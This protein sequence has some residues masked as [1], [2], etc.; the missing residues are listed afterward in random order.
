MTINVMALVN[1]SIRRTNSFIQ[2]I[3]KIRE[4][5]FPYQYSEEALKLIKVLIEEQV[6]YLKSIGP[7]SN[8]ESSKQLCTTS[9]DALADFLPLLGFIIR[10]TNVRNGFEFYGP[11][12][13]LS[14]QVLGNSDIRLVISS[15]WDYSPLTYQE[16]KGLKDFI[17]IGIPAT[18]S[19]NP[20][21]IP[22]AGHEL[23]HHLWAN[24]T[25]N[26]KLKTSITKEIIK[27]IEAR[28]KEFTNLYPN[29]IDS[30]EDLTTNFFAYEIW[31][32]AVEW[33]IQQSTELFC[34]FIGVNIF[35]EAYLHAFAYLLAPGMS[36]MRPVGYPE[37][38]TRIKDLVLAA[39]EYGI[40]CTDGYIDLYN[41]VFDLDD[42]DS[43]KKFWLEL[44]DQAVK[45]IVPELI[46]DADSI[47]K[48]S[49][50]I[51]FSENKINGILARF[52]MIVPAQNSESLQ[53][54][55]IAGW[56]A[57]H[58]AELWKDVSKITDRDSTLKELI[59]KTIE[60][61]EI[62]HLVKP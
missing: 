62:E 47:V 36:G 23:G 61:F 12:L 6:K 45:S 13:R 31:A 18:E 5:D 14:R 2:E 46:K 21:L 57:F 43:E 29:V 60:V 44:A 19:D 54:I 51:G 20:L 55:L 30:P 3:E 4:T 15:E 49:K 38:N 50:L 37:I 22:L 35:G 48:K 40:K 16:I 34:D 1:Y 32:T 28:W 10:S 56:R 33:A 59:L 17:F 39:N 24:S 11:L 26:S 42:S 41:E 27:L 9:L 53:N 52:K 25:L 7:N 58:D 8:K